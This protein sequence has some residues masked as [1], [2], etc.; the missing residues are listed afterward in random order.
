MLTRRG[1]AG[2]AVCA[3]VGFVA[4]GVEAQA[5]PEQKGGVTRTV[6]QSTDLDD[7][8]V[9]V[10]AMLEVAPGAAVARHTHPGLESA[11]VLEGQ[12]ELSVQGQPDKWVKAGGGFQIPP[13]TPHGGRNGDKTT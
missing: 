13:G 12:I 5:Q 11:Y 1:F 8:T 2:C 10:L 9:T 7:K 3:A 6:I 4:A